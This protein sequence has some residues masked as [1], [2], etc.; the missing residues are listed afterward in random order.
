MQGVT[1]PRPNQSLDLMLGNW[2]VEFAPSSHPSISYSYLPLITPTY[3]YLPFLAPPG[4]LYLPIPG[5][6]SRV[7]P[8]RPRRFR[9]RVY[10]CPSVVQIKRSPAEHCLP[11]KFLF[12]FPTMKKLIL[13]LLSVLCVA[14]SQSRAQDT[15][16]P[17]R[18]AVVGLIHDHVGGFFPRLKA[19]QTFNWSAS[20]KR[21]KCSSTAT[22]VASIW[23][24]ASF[25]PASKN[26]LPK[27]TYKPWPPS[28][29]FTTMPA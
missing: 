1:S 8:L 14:L 9:I 5:Y 13:V 29:P 2:P 18:L 27:P 28:P 6:A 22:P 20:S 19:G 7:W 26:S 4:G 17:L 25:T 21:I 11:I 3:S 16:S 15:N 24:Q 12:S 23:T 10:L